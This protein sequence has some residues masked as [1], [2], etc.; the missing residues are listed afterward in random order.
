MRSV[1]S[2]ALSLCVILLACAGAQAAELVPFVRVPA[3]ESGLT[4]VVKQRINEDP[5]GI[6]LPW[7][8]PLVD[9][10]DDGNLDISLLEKTNYLDKARKQSW[11]S[12]TD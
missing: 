12:A 11:L 9:I 6:K 3:E 2:L 7:M 10:K 8:S 5:T 4:H 1:R